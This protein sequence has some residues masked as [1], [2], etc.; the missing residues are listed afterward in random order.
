MDIAWGAYMDERYRGRKRHGGSWC[1]YTLIRVGDAYI[2]IG[3]SFEL[4]MRV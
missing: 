3:F 4:V 2:L 1:L